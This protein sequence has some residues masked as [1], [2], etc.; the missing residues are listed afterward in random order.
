[1]KTCNAQFLCFFLFTFC[2][3]FSSNKTNAAI[4]PE[5]CTDVMLQGFYWDSFDETSWLQLEAMAKEIGQNFDLIWLPPSGKGAYFNGVGNTLDVGYHP[6]YWSDQTSA[7]GYDYQL[8]SLISTLKS[9]GCKA[10]ADIVVNHRY[11]LGEDTKDVSTTDFCE[12]AEDDFGKYGKFKLTPAYMCPDDNLY[13][14]TSTCKATGNSDTGI[15]WALCPDL[16][17]T[18]AYVQNAVKAYLK[19]LKEEYGYSGWRY[20]FA[21]GFGGQ[22][23][24]DYNTASEAEFSVGEYWTEWDNE[25][26]NWLKA[27]NF[28]SSVFD[29]PGKLRTLKYGLAEGNYNEMA[30]DDGQYKRPTE[31]IKRGYSRY[32]V[33]FVDNHDT[34]REG[35]RYSGNVP[36]A[37]AFILSASGVPCVFWPHW[38]DHKEDINNMIAARKI[39]GIHSE[40]DARVTNTANGYYECTTTG[41]CGTLI[42]RIGK[43][44]GAPSGYETA[45]S[46]E[47]WAFYVKRTSDSC[48]GNA[49]IINL[50]VSPED[51]R[52]TDGVNVTM[53][54]SGNKA[55]FEIFYTTDGSEPTIA[56]TKYTSPF[57]LNT[58]ATIKAVAKDKDGNLSSI[59]SRR[60][61][62]GEASSLKIRFKKPD[63][64]GN[65]VMVW[66]WDDAK[67]VAYTGNQWPGI[68]AVSEGN[69]M[70][71]YTSPSGVTDFSII[72][73]N[74]NNGIQTNDTRVIE[75]MCFET[76]SSFERDGKQIYKVVEM[77]DCPDVENPG[78]TPGSMTVYFKKPE[79]WNEVKV[80]AWDTNNLATNYTGGQWPGILAKAE[81]NDMYS[82]TPPDGVTS[83]SVLF[84]NGVAMSGEQSADRHITKTICLETDNSHID[85]GRTIYETQ[86]MS[87]CGGIMT[88]NETMI[89]EISVVI[90][91]NPTNGILYL[92]ANEAILAVSVISLTGTSIPV[93]VSNNMIDITSFPAGV[94]I[95]KTFTLNGIHN[96]KII[97]K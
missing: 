31:M 76:G 91:P 49:Y 36:Q 24:G 78:E 11:G 35:T 46:G 50:D 7:W 73:N 28:R 52:Y 63:G 42:C 70:F 16:D 53:T 1:M 54:V 84:N 38:M 29:F 14:S 87:D 30:F 56:S 48:G 33:T 8:K 71:S 77:A 18:N 37:Y 34:Y 4:V 20:D 83:F 97:K 69:D 3:F 93:E 32:L 92:Q 72:F 64:W 5:K 89:N 68:A 43:W 17:H 60:Y 67:G 55:P 15:A 10:I 23:L 62:V 82:F 88:G 22:Y 81:G 65:Q 94:Y 40:S 59:K 39:I 45:C 19:W 2:L 79:N 27:T 6:R 12:F 47:G 57:F 96:T 90:Y 86:E 61:V 41:T 13:G 51:A 85:N 25:S 26:E 80:W 75:N 58:T 74:N 21:M 44:T 66:A 95:V 9:N